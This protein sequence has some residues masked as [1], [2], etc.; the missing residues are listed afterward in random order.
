[1]TAIIVAGIC[2]CGT[3]DSG[4]AG[5]LGD[6]GLFRDREV[7]SIEII[8]ENGGRADWSPAGDKIVFDRQNADGYFDLDVMTPDGTIV[9]SVTAG[10][11]L[12]NQRHNGNPAWHPAGKYII[13]LSEEERHYGAAN[14]WPGNP[15][16]GVFCN[17]WATDEGA[18]RF[19]KL[20]DIPMKQEKEDRIPAMGALN[21]HFSRDGSRLMWTERYGEGGKWGAWRVKVADF[22]E[23]DQ[24]PRLENE[25]VLFQPGPGM[26]L[27]VTALDFSP[28]DSTVLLAGN[29]DGQDEFGMDQYLFDPRTGELANLQNSPEVWEED[30][31]WS[32]DGQRI[33]YMTNLG[34]PLDFD[35]PDWYWQPH[36][37][38]YWAMN[39]D[40]SDKRRLTYFNQPGYPEYVGRPAIVAASSFDPEGKRLVGILGVD[41][42]SG[43]KADFKLKLVLIEFR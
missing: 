37:G 14:K 17:L 32:P 19:W 10:N 27:Y 30:A 28:D 26:G 13:F 8:Q 41:Y 36:T 11:P 22:R 33:V 21:P 5:S 18:K 43:E 42:G 2:G 23:D 24:G 9:S 20:T 7:R 12:I 39:S 25:A 16:I 40:G 1:M 15:G 38:E 34:S 4:P 31:S 6:D 3:R 29:L 35:D